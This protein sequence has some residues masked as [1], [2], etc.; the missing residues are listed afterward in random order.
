MKKFNE[1]ELIGIALLLICIIFSIIGKHVFGLEGDFLSAAAT[2]FAAVVAFLLFQ[3]WRDQQKFV[4][5][6]KYQNL[7]KESGKSLFTKYSNFHIFFRTL[8]LERGNWKNAIGS[9]DVIK[10]NYKNVMQELSTELFHNSTLLNEYQLC[11]VQLNLDYIEHHQ[12]IEVYKTDIL[13]AYNLLND[14]DEKEEFVDKLVSGT[15]LVDSKEIGNIIHRS[16]ELCG[17][18]ML[19][20]LNKIL[21]D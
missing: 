5:V 11:L 3:D 2:L 4:L 10:Q 14:I 7:I 17:Y 20:Y 1:F 18:D 21:K 8:D 16:N 6:E 12:K 13:R 9:T 19:L 15:L